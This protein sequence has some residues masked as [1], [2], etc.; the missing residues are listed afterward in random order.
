M[1]NMVISSTCIKCRYTLLGKRKMIRAIKRT[2]FWCWVR[3][4][5]SSLLFSRSFN[6]IVQVRIAVAYNCDISHLAINIQSI[7]VDS[8]HGFGRR[9][10]R[11]SGIVMRAKKPLFFCCS[12]KKN[13]RAG[14]WRF[15]HLESLCQLDQ[16]GCPGCIVKRS[17]INL[18]SFKC[19]IQAKMVPMC[20]INDI[21][22]CSI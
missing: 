11:I 9:I 8:S 17:I 21:F 2:F 3:P 18:I 14:R 12:S 10:Y 13:N 7:H 5:P 20:H 15:K 1:L 19:R 22:V 4:S 16:S 6:I